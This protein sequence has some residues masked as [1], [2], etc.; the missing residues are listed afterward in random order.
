MTTPATKNVLT[1]AE[2][3]KLIRWL[4]EKKDTLNNL[5]QP[6][7]AKVATGDLGF[8]VTVANVYGGCNV[9]GIKLGQREL[10]GQ[11]YYNYKNSNQSQTIAKHLVYLYTRLGEPVPQPL[12]EIANS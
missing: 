4:D 5:S 10:K 6:Q 1:K 12:Q 8:L 2:N 3:Y 7:I 11:I 9:L